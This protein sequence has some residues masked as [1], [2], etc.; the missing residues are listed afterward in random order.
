MRKL[1]RKVLANKMYKQHI[2][3][4]YFKYIWEAQKEAKKVRY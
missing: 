2:K 1:A 3:H 4:K